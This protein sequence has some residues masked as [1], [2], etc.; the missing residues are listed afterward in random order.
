MVF[1]PSY[2]TVCIH[3]NNDI[4]QEFKCGKM[5]GMR[6]SEITNTLVIISNHTKGLHEDKL[7]GDIL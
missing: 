2:E 3:T 1:N 4:I 6:I 7:Y 5:G